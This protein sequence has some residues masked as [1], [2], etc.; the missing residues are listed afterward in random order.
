MRKLRA[1]IALTLI[2]L[3]LLPGLALAFS[4]TAKQGG[5]FKD[6]PNQ[7]KDE[8]D[9]F[10]LQIPQGIFLKNI[11]YTV[12]KVDA[13]QIEMPAGFFLTKAVDLTFSYTQN[14]PEYNFVKPIRVMFTFDYIDFKRA[15]NLDT[16]QPIE[17]FCLGY[18]DKNT[19][20]WMQAPSTIF[21]DGQSGV[22]EALM[23]QGSGRYALMWSSAANP[24]LSTKGGDQI[25]MFLNYEPL[26][27]PVP[28]FVQNNRTMV[29]LTVIAQNMGA[30]VSWFQDDQRIEISPNGVK[31]VKLW[32]GEL[33]ADNDGTEVYCEVPPQIVNGR[34]FVPL[35]FVIQALG[36]Q[37]NWDGQTRSIFIDKELSYQNS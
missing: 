17:R 33:R 35:G 25:R 30:K 2:G 20:K 7:L 18:Y 24:S 10:T 16:S 32:I 31:R 22:V 8:A 27:A 5:F 11:Q 23:S 37:I 6:A 3:L 28:P 21:W 19:G 14:R 12:T 26:T 9:G 15:S 34:T 1:A 29:P 4:T 13:S 36:A